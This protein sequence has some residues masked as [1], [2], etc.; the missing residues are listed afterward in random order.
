MGPCLPRACSRSPHFSPSTPAWI[1]CPCQ[2]LVFLLFKMHS[3]SSRS[4][5]SSLC[6]G[7]KLLHSNFFS[8]FISGRALE[9]CSLPLPPSSPPWL[10]FSLAQAPS[11]L[12]LSAPSSYLTPIFS[13][14][15]L[16][17]YSHP[18]DRSQTTSSAIHLTDPKPLSQRYKCDLLVLWR[19]S[20]RMQT[21]TGICG[22]PMA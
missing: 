6:S 7:L 20:P 3:G 1:S 8:H 11:L 21:T 17:Q 19:G 10:S 14:L 12:S 18:E 22:N 2:S 13:V 15:S 4:P 9:F 16:L 5:C